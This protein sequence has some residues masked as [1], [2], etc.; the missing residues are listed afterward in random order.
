VQAPDNLETVEAAAVGPDGRVWLAGRYNLSPDLG[1]GPL[2]AGDIF[3][4][5]FYV[6]RLDASGV[7]EFSAGFADMGGLQVDTIGGLAVDADGNIVVAGRDAGTSSSWEVIKISPAGQMLW[8]THLSC[9][10][11]CQ[12]GGLGVD[13]QGNV[14]L[15]GSVRGGL[16]W[17]THTL[18]TNPPG[19]TDLW[20]GQLLSADGGFGWVNHFGGSS[21]EDLKGL[22]VD[23]AN[24]RVVVAGSFRGPTLDV[25]GGALPLG[26]AVAQA[27]LLASFT[28]DGNHVWSQR[29]SGDNGYCYAEALAANAS[30]DLSVATNC[31]AA[32]F[33]APGTPCQVGVF[34]AA[35]TLQWGHAVDGN[36]GCN[37]RVAIGAGG[38]VAQTVIDD[39]TITLEGQNRCSLT[40][41]TP[42]CWCVTRPAAPRPSSRP[43]ASPAPTGCMPWPS[44]A[45]APPWPVAAWSSPG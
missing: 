29:F 25:G 45:P 12:V 16:T 31:N 21:Y 9:D 8:Q 14:Y 7:P 22:A 38:E 5:S 36:G 43:S 6:V 13:V 18:Q 32:P 1:Q 27:G 19:D 35:G 17:G 41:V 44:T 3:T 37:G 23:A 28:L 4:Y 20:F 15:G 26:T 24:G 30:G 42:A 40:P 34:D 11:G 33:G 39:G 10:G 2:P